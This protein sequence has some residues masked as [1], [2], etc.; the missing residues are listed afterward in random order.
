MVKLLL[1]AVGGAG[2]SVLRYLVSGWLQRWSDTWPVGNLVVNVTGCLLIGF[3]GT[4]F[5]GPLMVRPEWR[6]GIIVGVLGGYTT[7]STFGWDTMKLV[8]GRQFG[9]AALNVLLSVGAG[10][11]AVWAGSRV[12]Q[13]LYGP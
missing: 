9:F 6:L 13:A 1:I 3:L 12:A 4:A 8:D 10:L 7:F 5:T 2:G 11:V